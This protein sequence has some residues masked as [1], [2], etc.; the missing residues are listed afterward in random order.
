MSTDIAN[1]QLSID[2]KQALDADRALDRLSDT[3]DDATR[4][5]DRLATGSRTASAAQGALAA[6]SAGVSRG[7][8]LQ[9]G[10]IQQ[11]G[12][13]VQDFAVQVAGGQSALIAF[14]QQG[15]QLAGILG[16]GGAVIGAVIAISAALAGPLMMAL[17][18]AKEETAA[19]TN[20]FEDMGDRFNEIALVQLDALI[21]NTEK[22]IK[23]LK[24]AGAVVRPLVTDME[25][26]GAAFG[27]TNTPS[28]F[29][30]PENAVFM[31][32]IG[33][34]ITTTA[35][36]A[37]S[38]GEQVT[39]LEKSLAD[40]ITQRRIL[41]G[42]EQAEREDPLNNIMP[43]VEAMNKRRFTLQ[44]EI[45]ALAAYDAQVRAEKSEQYRREWLANRNQPW[46]VGV[47]EPEL[48]QEWYDRVQME[49]DI[50]QAKRLAEAQKNA[51]E[52]IRIEQSVFNSQMRMFNAL[53]GIASDYYE[54]RGDENEKAFEQAKNLNAGLIVSN[55]A[56]GIMNALK[57]GLPGARWAEAGAIGLEG[58]RQLAANAQS[59]FGGGSV[60]PPQAPPV[61]TNNTQTN[62]ISVNVA[63]GNSEDVIRVLQNYFDADGQFVTT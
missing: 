29:N 11:V 35:S 57:T 10:A 39:A 26:L 60:A 1:L 41:L 47:P 2:S 34:A 13:Q 32:E 6:T 4:S 30:S 7:F 52:R 50:A 27:E 42:L 25:R 38:A 19:L 20:D 22:E 23:A 36:A 37:A 54:K 48:V 31:K 16:P 55:T 43:S 53:G 12:F 3:A 58:I 51:D 61:T 44:G 40:Y 17:R 15:S 14:G 24:D 45:D 46:M 9:K 33:G 18:G 62:N 59:E 49:D 21:L 5:V 63:G 28:F 56:A 8:R